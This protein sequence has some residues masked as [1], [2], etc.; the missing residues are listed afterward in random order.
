MAAHPL[1]PGTKIRSIN[2][3]LDHDENDD[4]RRTPPGSVGVIRLTEV[5]GEGAEYGGFIYHTDFP[6]TGATVC[7]YPTE[8]DDAARYQIVA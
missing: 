1:P 6:D 4:E 2:G 3:E 8:V 7:L 5:W